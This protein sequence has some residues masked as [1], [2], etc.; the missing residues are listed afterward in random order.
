MRKTR[1][2]DVTP[3]ERAI[4]AIALIKLQFRELAGATRTLVLDG[5]FWRV[6]ALL[7]DLDA[8]VER[9]LPVT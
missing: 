5:L 2:E 8:A 7:S 4:S 1:F 3:V 9:R 6:S